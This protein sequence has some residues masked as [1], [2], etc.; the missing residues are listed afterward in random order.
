[1]G[2]DDEQGAGLSC[3]VKRREKDGA[4]A[5]DKWFLCRPLEVNWTIDP[6]QPLPNLITEIQN[7]VCKGQFPTV[8]FKTTRIFATPAIF[9]P[10]ASSPV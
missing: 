5:F 7:F 8:N 6:F 3:T 2:K 10:H 4:C 9:K 1:M